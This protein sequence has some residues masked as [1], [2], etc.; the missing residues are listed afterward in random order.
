MDDR[1]YSEEA[2][3]KRPLGMIVLLLIVVVACLTGATVFFV[4]SA[5]ANLEKRENLRCANNLALIVKAAIV[6]SNEHRFFPHM[7]ALA[8]QNTK[9]QVSDAFRTLIYMGYLESPE[10]FCCPSSKAESPPS[11]ELGQNPKLWD[12]SQSANSKVGGLPIHN[13][14]KVSL[15]KNKELSYTYLKRKVYAPSARSDT[16]IFADKSTRAHQSKR[17]DFDGPGFHVAYGE[18]HVI[19]EPIKKEINVTRA[20]MRLYMEGGD[21]PRLPH[22][23]H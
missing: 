10:V 11:F 3:G 13:S 4:V 6:Y 21:P 19:L 8:K 23:H 18:G 7:T 22:D 2:S 20:R 17:R 14:S 9:E 12:W 1:E 5:R 16:M 15:F